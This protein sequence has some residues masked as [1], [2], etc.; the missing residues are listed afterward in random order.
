MKRI[1]LLLAL[2]FAC[3]MMQAAGKT[4]HQL[5]QE[6]VDLRFGMFIHFNI[7]TFSP[8]D[9]PDPDQPASTFNPVRLDCRQWARAA[10]DANMSYG[11]LTTKHHI[12]LRST[13]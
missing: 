6:F 7:P 9:W 12:R 11:C 8:E 3:N 2:L 5:Q 10:K 13:N 4:L 1:F